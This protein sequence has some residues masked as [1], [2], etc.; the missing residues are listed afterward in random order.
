MEWLGKV[1]RSLFGTG[2]DNDPRKH[3][4]SSTNHPHQ[5]PTSISARE[6]SDYLYKYSG[7][8]TNLRQQNPTSYSSQVKPSIHTD[9]PSQHPHVNVKDQSFAYSPSLEKLSFDEGNK[10]QNNYG[11]ESRIKSDSHKKEKLPVY[12]IPEEIRALIEKGKVPDVLIKPLS[13]STYSNYFASLLY[14][15]DVY[16][17]TWSDFV[18]EGITVQIYQELTNRDKTRY[19]NNDQKT[20][21]KKNPLVYFEF[22]HDRVDRPFLLSRDYVFLKPSGKMVDPFKGT[23]CR[24]E[25]SKKVVVEFGDDFHSP[26]RKSFDQ[27]Y[28]VSFS[29]N[30]VCLKRCHQAVAAASEPSSHGLLF[31]SYTPIRIPD[32]R[33]SASS[34]N[35]HLDTKQ[36]AAVSGILRCKGFPPYLVEGPT[37]VDNSPFGASSLAIQK[38]KAVVGVA[39]SYIYKSFP[40]SKIL[41]AAPTNKACD[42]LLRILLR[43]I[44]DTELFRSNAAFRELEDVPVEVFGAS[45][46]DGEVFDCPTLQKLKSYRVITSTFISCFRLYSAGITKGHFTHIFLMDASAATEPET[47]VALVNLACKNTTVVVTGCSSEKPSRIR[48]PISQQHGLRRSYFERLLGQ[49]PYSEDNPLFVTHLS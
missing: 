47:M 36:Q 13:A 27:N 38:T 22:P 2:E 37:R 44:P 33:N 19:K 31:P 7:S 39:A 49:L 45:S 4:G 1:F 15:E 9:N 43:D 28:D 3:Y 32:A 26:R 20:S 23:V 17:E 35:L 46:Y 8:S 29:F 25:K 21:T 11:K 42:D 5:N 6:T 34:S 40:N 30:R 10:K 18:L 14:A 41:I 16:V 12:G 24:V 48:S